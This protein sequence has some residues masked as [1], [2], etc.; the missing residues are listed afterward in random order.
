VIYKVIIF[1]FLLIYMSGWVLWLHINITLYSPK[2]F[3]LSRI[4][5]VHIKSDRRLSQMSN[6]YSLKDMQDHAI[7]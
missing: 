2:L 1:T 5:L 3:C 6:G 7:L 4:S